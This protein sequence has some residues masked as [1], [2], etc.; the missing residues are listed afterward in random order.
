MVIRFTH[1]FQTVSE[2]GDVEGLDTFAIDIPVATLRI[3]E[4]EH[5]MVFRLQEFT[6]TAIVE[7]TNDIQNLLF[8][9]LFGTIIDYYDDPIDEEFDLEKLQD[10]IP[11]LSA[12]IRNDLRPE[13]E[14]CFTIRI[15]P[16][17]VRRDPFLCNEDN[18]GAANYFCETTV[19]IEDDDGRFLPLLL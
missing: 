19:C 3:A 13:D 8:D 12:I 10:T 14:E 5:P 11:S 1:R 17:H 16:I 15:S 4:R 18:S 6:S 7:P 2:S 9:A